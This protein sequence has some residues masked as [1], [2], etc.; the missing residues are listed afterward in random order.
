MKSFREFFTFMWTYKPVDKEVLESYFH[1]DDLVHLSEFDDVTSAVAGTCSLIASSSP[2]PIPTFHWASFRQ[3]YLNYSQIFF[4]HCYTKLRHSTGNDRSNITLPT[5]KYQ[6]Q[7]RIFTVTTHAVSATL[8]L[9]TLLIP[10]FLLLWIPMSRFLTSVTVSVSMLIFAFVMGS[11][12]KVK[13]QDV[14]IGTGKSFA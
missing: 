3:S 14:L 4:S 6:P 8:V 13:T 5:T 12:P 1:V 10:V 9:G 2:P 11:F 7:G